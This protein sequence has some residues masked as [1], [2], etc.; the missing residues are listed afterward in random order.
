M[1]ISFVRTVD[2]SL[3][4][5]R[6]RIKIP[7][8]PLIDK[9]HTVNIV[10]EL[11][12]ADDCD[13]LIFSKHFHKARDYTM[14]TKAKE[15]GIK[16]VY[17][18]CDNHFNTTNSDYY[19]SMTALADIV[20]CNTPVMKDV[21]LEEAGR[22]AS[23]V[24]DPYELPEKAPKFSPG[25]V[26]NIL[27]YGHGV[28]LNTLPPVLGDLSKLSRPVNLRVISNAPFRGSMSSVKIDYIPWS[29]ATMA[30]GLE[31]CDMIM[32]PTILDDQTKITKSHNRVTEGIRSGRFV[33]AHPLPS[34]EKYR[35]FAYIHNNLGVGIEWALRNP[36]KVVDAIEGGQ[37]F[38]NVTISPEDI[39]GQW[40]EA[41]N[42]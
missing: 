2:E 19:R 18:I 23:I 17:D 27:W 30:A 16:V 13:F 28:N 1:K 3:A 32:V 25:D 7:M 36:D 37:R 12:N 42:G 34:Y 5:F 24:D 33:V 29:P 38:I 20:T 21:I 35:P 31:W 4:S 39:A 22:F 40:E 15:A 14:A 8:Q 26:L 6:Y 9:G 11:P 41:L 10:D